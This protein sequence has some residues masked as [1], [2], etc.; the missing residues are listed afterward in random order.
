M[1]TAKIVV[2]GIAKDE[3]ASDPDGAM[4]LTAVLDG[5]EGAA[6]LVRVLT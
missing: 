5:I 6:V 4:R 3:V 1:T 2:I